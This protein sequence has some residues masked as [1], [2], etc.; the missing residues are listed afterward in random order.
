MHL[1]LA[2]FFPDGFTYQENMLP[3]WHKRLGYDVEVIAS[4]LSFDKGG[5]DIILPK[6]TSYLNEYNIPVTRLAY[7]SPMQ[8]YRKLNRFI[9]LADALEKAAPNI[10][11]IHGCQFLDI[12]IVVAYLENHPGIKVYVDNH[13]DYSNSARNWLSKHV[14]HR[15]I[16]KRCA[17]LVA[18]Y[19][20]MFWGVLPA[21]VDFLVE[22][23]DLPRAKCALLVMGAD[24]DEVERASNSPVRISIRNRFRFTDD[25]FVVVTGGKIDTEKRQTLQLMDAVRLMDEHIKL[26]VFGPIASEM[27]EEFDEKFDSDKMVHVSWANASESYDYFAAADVVCFPGRHSVY[28]E[29][30]AAMGKPLIVKRWPGTEHVNI[31]DNVMFLDSGGA[32][33]IVR[34]IMRVSS[35]DS[36]ASQIKHNASCAAKSFLYSDIAKRSIELAE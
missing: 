21:R 29:Q 27:K 9:G 33:E 4:L 1:C 13:A 32:E 15:L 8:I 18:P 34:A 14:L 2:C 6:P 5:L 23:Y 12:D 3:K 7:K 17:K 19:T 35:S 30:A 25:D 16:W 26:L 11:F 10:L 31:N 22:N 28:W 36:F 24:D 20:S